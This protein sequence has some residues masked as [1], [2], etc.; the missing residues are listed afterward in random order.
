MAWRY[1]TVSHLADLHSDIESLSLEA[2]FDRIPLGIAIFDRG[3]R[4]V[5]NNPAWARLTA[6]L[7]AV[8]FGG[9]SP[10]AIDA[11]GD[12]FRLAS[13]GLF[14]RAMAGEKVRHEALRL[15]AGG[16]ARYWDVTVTPL[17]GARRVEGLIVVASDATDRILAYEALEQR[18]ADRTHELERR[19]QVAESLRDMLGVLNSSQPL[20]EILEC[21][22]EQ[23]G[24]LLAA[25]GVALYRLEE[26]DNL[27]IQASHGLDPRYVT[28]MYVPLGEGGVGTA[29]VRREPVAFSDIRTS[30]VSPEAIAREPL[31][32]RECLQWLASHYRSLLAVPLIV[33]DEVYGGIVMHYN[34]PHEFSEEEIQLGVAFGNQAALAIENARLFAEAQGKAILEERQRLARELHD[35]V[36]QA[37]YSLTLLAEAGRR[38]VGAGDLKRAGE[39]LDRLG[40]VAQ[41]SLNEMRLLVYELRPYELER[42]GLVGALQQRLDAVEKR[43][44]M[45]TRLLIEGDIDLP[46][47]LEEG[48]YRIAQEAL[49][50][51]LKHAG[52][53]A[54]TVWVRASGEWVELEVLDNGKGFDPDTPADAGGMGLSSMKERADLMGGALTIQSVP[55]RG[56]SVKVSVATQPQTRSRSNGYGL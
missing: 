15:G 8:P 26:D 19:R 29:A 20:G 18:L 22:V 28:R 40:S 48:L 37:L 3:G 10:G 25:G 31:V 49:N 55:G 51:A 53:T 30:L 44:S 43:A 45:E 47:P 41:Q 27:R 50:N 5:R 52:A 11:A 56:T 39:Y 12:G 21:I 35:S 33:K 14:L 16:R 23:A 32:R 2:A 13:S 38:Q 17:S 34:K 42:E 1:G 54:V 9:A 36:T 46:A 6:D 7:A 4:L 24:K